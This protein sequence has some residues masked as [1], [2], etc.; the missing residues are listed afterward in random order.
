MITAN[1]RVDLSVCGQ[2]RQ[3]HCILRQGVET[4]FGIFCVDPTVAT[5]LADS[6]LESSFGETGL[7][8]NGLD[9]GVLDEGKEEMVLS[10]VRIMHGLL[11]RL[12]LPEDLNGSR[13]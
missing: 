3:I 11:N 7:L 8:D 6:C 2:G 4:L 13:A 9:A 5:D 1:N 10:D 12:G